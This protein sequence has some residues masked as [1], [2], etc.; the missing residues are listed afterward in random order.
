MSDLGS[1]QNQKQEDH[2]R[3]EADKGGEDAA[4]ESPGLYGVILGTASCHQHQT[5]LDNVVGVTLEKLGGRHLCGLG[6]F[7]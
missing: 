3:S 7:D 6:H 1:P 4:S 5:Q 2:D